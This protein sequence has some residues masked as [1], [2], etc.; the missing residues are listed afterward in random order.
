M[1][2]HVLNWNQFLQ[3]EELKFE[4][5]FWNT[6][7]DSKKKH[8]IP[9]CKVTSIKSGYYSILTLLSKGHS[10]NF[11]LHKQSEKQ[12]VLLFVTLRQIE[13]KGLYF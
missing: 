1:N 10:I 9:Q 13:K 7:L 11:P 2:V 4:G 12:E 8:W 6:N 3:I 5:P